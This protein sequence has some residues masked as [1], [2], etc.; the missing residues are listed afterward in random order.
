[1]ESLKLAFS[2]GCLLSEEGNLGQ[3][4]P[5]SRWRAFLSKGHR[6]IHRADRNVEASSSSVMPFPLFSTI[7]Y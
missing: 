2:H 3:I 6:A 7:T 1:M 5:V 4:S